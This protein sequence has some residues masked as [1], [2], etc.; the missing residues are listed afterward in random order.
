M[1]KLI[2]LLVL[3]AISMNL[4]ACTATSNNTHDSGNKTNTKAAA[5]TTERAELTDSQ[6][7]SIIAEELYDMIKKK[8]S[9][10]DAGSSRYSIHKVTQDRKGDYVVTGTVVLYDK[11]GRMTTGYSDGSGSYTKT[12]EIKING[13]LGYAYYGGKI[14]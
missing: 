2:C 13:E 8:Y 6:I 14:N 12:F 11:Y 5:T 10:A 9:E 1:K 4:Y 3:L 7:E